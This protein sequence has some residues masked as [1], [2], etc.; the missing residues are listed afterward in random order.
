MGRNE[1]D[2]ASQ[3]G[4]DDGFDVA[5][6]PSAR[7]DSPP[8]W[9]PVANLLP[10]DSPR[11]AGENLDHAR[12]LA[13]SGAVLPPII[14]HS[15]TMRVIDGMHRLHA[16][17]MRGQDKIQVQFYDG[18]SDG[19]FVIAV[20][21]NIKHGLPLSLADRREA[22]ARIVRSHP[23]WSDRAIASVTGLEHKTVGTIR[24]RLSGDSAQPS[25]RLGRDGRLR[26][27][28]PAARRRLASEV[29]NGS[30]NASLREIAKAAGIAVS[31]AKDVRE[32]VR[33]GQDPVP[34]RQHDNSQQR[35]R[36]SDSTAEQSRVARSDRASMLNRLKN[37]PSLRQTELGRLI[38]R[39]LDSGPAASTEQAQLVSGVPAHCIEQV[40]RLA[41][42]SGDAWYS[43]ADH[44]DRRRSRTS[45]SQ[46]KPR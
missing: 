34:P 26:P 38:L 22:A 14:V 46:G 33:A 43:F 6:L 42:D 28:D 29:I 12:A 18:D 3:S 21:A 35:R 13:E 32:R 20:Q 17:R 39:W 27:T 19:A 15:A 16:A 4:G 37:D 23:T 10:S 1:A 24:R 30:P 40:A 8:V 41:R 2:P 11:L 45:P 44:L 9:V 5:R 36:G 25:T 31:T 7:S